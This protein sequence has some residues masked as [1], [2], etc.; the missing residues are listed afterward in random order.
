M[1]ASSADCWAKQD[2]TNRKG[3][4]AI[5]ARFIITRILRVKQ[6]SSGAAGSLSLV[7]HQF[8][9]GSVAFLRNLDKGDND[10]LAPCACV[11]DHRIGNALGDL[12]FLIGRAALE[13]GDLNERHQDLS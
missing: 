7:D 6:L 4:T 5:Q 9:A 10:G 11:F 8:A 2:S 13:H 3:T 1:A 12:P